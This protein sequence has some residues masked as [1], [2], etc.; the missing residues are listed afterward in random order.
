M[1]NSLKN[2]NSVLCQNCTTSAKQKKK[3]ILKKVN[4][5]KIALDLTD[6][7]CMGKKT[8]RH[9]FFFLTEEKKA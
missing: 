5:S 8:L 2:E 1:D 6:F 3:E 7:H 4:G 9:F